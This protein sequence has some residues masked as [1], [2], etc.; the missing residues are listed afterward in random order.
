ML[1]IAHRLITIKNANKILVIKTDRSK[2]QGRTNFFCRIV[3][4]IL[5]CGKPIPFHPTGR[6][7]RKGGDTSV[8]KQVLFIVLP[9]EIR[10][11]YK[12]RGVDSVG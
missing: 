7:Q 1:I 8:K 2:M 9:Q 12:A 5:P 6:L 4:R 3:K 10:K 11:S